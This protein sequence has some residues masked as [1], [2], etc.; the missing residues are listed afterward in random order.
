MALQ[1]KVCGITRKEDLQAIAAAGTHYAGFIFYEK[2]PRY[3]GDKLLP[4]TVQ[5][6]R[7]VQKTGVFVNAAEDT[8]RQQTADYG[9]DLLQLHGAETPADCERLRRFRPVMKAFRLK[10][11]RDLAGVRPYEQ[12]CDFFLF[13]TAGKLYGG[14]GTGF[15]WTILRH[16]DGQTPFFLSGGIGPEHAEALRQFN[17]PQWTGVDINSRFET[18]PGIKN[19]KAIKQFIWDLNIS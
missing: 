4:A 15:D 12:V 16:Y 8:I 7:Q 3:V 1:I 6:F 17:H 11:A 5:N 14:N 19:T 18:A 9:L 13:D 2:S 10:D